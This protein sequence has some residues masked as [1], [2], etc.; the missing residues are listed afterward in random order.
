MTSICGPPQGNLEMV[1]L[2]PVRLVLGRIDVMRA[3]HVAVEIALCTGSMMLVAEGLGAGVEVE[4][5]V[6]A[7]EAQIAFVGAQAH[8]A[9]TMLCPLQDIN[10][11]SMT[12]HSVVIELRVS[13]NSP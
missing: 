2:V 7:S 4:E 10:I 11:S 8:A 3:L 12:S 6:T 13:E 5:M 9:T 1:V